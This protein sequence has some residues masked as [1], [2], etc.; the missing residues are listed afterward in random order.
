MLISLGQKRSCVK[1]EILDFPPCIDFEFHSLTGNMYL[2][3]FGQKV[4]EA[5]TLDIVL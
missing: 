3:K 4:T 1:E 2:I 5:K